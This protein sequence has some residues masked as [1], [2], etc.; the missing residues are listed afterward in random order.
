MLLGSW[1]GCN[2]YQ[3]RPIIWGQLLQ[4]KARDFEFSLRRPAFGGRFLGSNFRLVRLDFRALAVEVSRLSS[5]CRGGVE[6]C[7]EVCQGLSRLTPR[8]TGVEVS[9]FVSRL[10]RLLRCRGVE[11][12]HVHS[13]FCRGTMPICATVALI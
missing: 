3:I 1:E 13:D 10:S 4:F 11:A 7:V 2:F 12:L 6:V 8:V 9:R 5:L